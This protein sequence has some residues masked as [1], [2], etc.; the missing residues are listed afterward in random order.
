MLTGRSGKGTM[1]NSTFLRTFLT[2]L[3]YRDE[4]VLQEPEEADKIGRYENFIME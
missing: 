1:K 4:S 2:Y 3:T